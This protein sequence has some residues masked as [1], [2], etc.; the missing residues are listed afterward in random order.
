MVPVTLSIP[1]EGNPLVRQQLLQEKTDAGGPLNSFASPR[2]VAIGATVAKVSSVW[3]ALEAEA[4]GVTTVESEVPFYRK[5]NTFL[6]NLIPLRSAIKNFT[7]GNI[8]DGIVDLS[9][10]VFG[11][12]TAGAATVGKAAKVL[13]S[14]LSAG[15]KA[16]RIGKTLGLGAISLVNPLDGAADLLRAT[17][18]GVASAGKRVINDAI[19]DI[20]Q[21][22]GTHTGYDLV[23]AS[24]Q[25]DAAAMGTFKTSGETQ[26]GAAVLQEG[27]WYAFDTATQSSF[28]KALDDFQPS[29]R[30]GTPAL[31]AWQNVLTAPSPASIQI[32]KD[33]GKLLD[34]H[35]GDGMPSAAFKNGYEEG[36]RGTDQRLCQ[37][38]EIRRRDEAGTTPGP[39]R[40]RGGHISPA[41][42]K[43]GCPAR[44]Q[45]HTA[46]QRPRKCR[47]RN[48]HPRTSI[49]LP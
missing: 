4:Q 37:G 6:L 30:G 1:D 23:A 36:A 49:L 22:R 3:G 25:Y 18:R 14:T 19:Q 31:R 7:D 8:G 27:K 35:Q 41:A 9:L 40:K 24:K 21:L 10:D 46:F 5:L 38:H 12:M 2:S 13:T 28:G 32:R 17:G 44:A 43:A 39:N 11:V 34:R 26:Q 20:R 47:R 16:L 15:S 29:V 48:V 45:R 33:W 42:G